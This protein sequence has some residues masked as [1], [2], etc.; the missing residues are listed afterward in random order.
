M[1]GGEVDFVNTSDKA[2]KHKN[3][4]IIM[5]IFTCRINVGLVL[6]GWFCASKVTVCY[7]IP[8]LI[9]GGIFSGS[10]YQF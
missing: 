2:Q 7:L 3:T 6:I 1:R 5:C 9:S 10:N 8:A 4:P